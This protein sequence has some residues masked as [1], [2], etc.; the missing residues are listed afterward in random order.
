MNLLNRTT[1]FAPWNERAIRGMDDVGICIRN[2]TEATRI[3]KNKK[4]VSEYGEMGSY[5]SGSSN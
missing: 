3:K 1:F 5:D 4:V 2:V